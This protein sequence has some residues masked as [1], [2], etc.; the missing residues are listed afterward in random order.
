MQSCEQSAWIEHADTQI[1]QTC[2]A[3]MALMY[4]GY[5]DPQPVSKAVKLVMSRQR[6]V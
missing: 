5:P 3:A 6:P 2:W 4:A 1:V